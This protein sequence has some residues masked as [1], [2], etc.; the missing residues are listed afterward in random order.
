MATS[1]TRTR[2]AQAPTVQTPTPARD[3]RGP[4]LLAELRARLNAHLAT[5]ARAGMGEA[6]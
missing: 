1:Q 6:R 3:E 4:N 5:R 2:P